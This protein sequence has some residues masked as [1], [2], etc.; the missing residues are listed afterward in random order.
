MYETDISPLLLVVEVMVMVVEVNW[1]FFPEHFALFSNTWPKLQF[2]HK[3]GFNGKRNTS[4]TG[5]EHVNMSFF[6]GLLCK[7][8][9]T[10]RKRRSH[11]SV[12]P[13]DEQD[14]FTCQSLEK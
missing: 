3:N 5:D 11:L 8:N 7:S 6:N 13:P 9:S 10:R 12:R 2:G 14:V 1:R 4:L